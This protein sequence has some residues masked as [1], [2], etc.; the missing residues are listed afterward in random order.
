M[1]YF[2]DYDT[3]RYLTFDTLNKAG[4]VHGLFTRRG[5]VSPEPWASLNL[6]GTTG[7]SREHVV[8]NR[9]RMFDALHQPVESIFDSWQVHGTEVLVATAPRPLNQPHK[10]AD[11]LITN[12]PGI[13][14]TMRFA[15]CVP[16]LLYDPEKR[17]AALV[18]AGWQG[19]VKH[20]GRI[21]V[22]AMCELF[23]SRPKAI[24]AAIGPSIGPDHYEVGE[25][26]LQRVQD[27]F[28]AE[29]EQVICN[30]NGRRH[31]DLWKANTMVLQGA[32]VRQIEVAELC[33][34]CHV[35]DWFSHRKEHG[36]TGRFGA[37][38]CL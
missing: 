7:D 32:G 9:R 19:T 13:T 5:G 2:T 1:I 14:L 3:V 11:I 17:V 27:A 26:V 30:V 37:A 15:D 34:A 33:T 16:I 8:E 29:S 22:E 35:E 20:A 28:G 36:K 31:F 24:L 38:I 4:V 25:D 21:A 10:P 12:K 18:H 6:G 23:D